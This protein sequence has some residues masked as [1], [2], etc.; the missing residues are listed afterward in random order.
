MKPDRLHVSFGKSDHGGLTIRKFATLGS[1]EGSTP[2]IR[3][4]LATG[5]DLAGDLQ[6]ENT[7]LLEQVWALTRERD[8]LAER[9]ARA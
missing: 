6:A 9:L 1:F 7:R 3:A 8:Q 4:D 2:Y 5:S